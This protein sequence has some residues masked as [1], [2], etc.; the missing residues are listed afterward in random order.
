VFAHVKKSHTK[1][2]R[3]PRGKLR[4]APAYFLVVLF[5]VTVQ[6][7]LRALASL[8]SNL[9]KENEKR[10]G[11]FGHRYDEDDREADE[12]WESVD[13]H[14]DSR[15]RDRREARLKKDLEE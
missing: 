7:I 5:V 10:G 12:I 4:Q 1:Q 13:N 11:D 6:Q 8:L 14:M 15:R 3:L 9:E 2:K